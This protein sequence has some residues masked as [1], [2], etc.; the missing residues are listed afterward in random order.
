M[1]EQTI[2]SSKIS[3]SDDDGG[4]CV[5]QIITSGNATNHRPIGAN[6]AAI[7][8]WGSYGMNEA[9]LIMPMQTAPPAMRSA[10]ALFLGSAGLL[11]HSM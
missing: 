1:P 2:A 5:R 8:T 9:A 7:F 6:A 4:C 11:A 10:A 3:P